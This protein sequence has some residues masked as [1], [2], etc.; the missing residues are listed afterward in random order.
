MTSIKTSLAFRMASV[1][2]AICLVLAWPCA[3]AFASSIP[4]VET[5]NYRVA[6]YYSANFNMQDDAGMRSGYGYEA[7][8]EI[9]KHMQCTFSY[10]GYDK[11]PDESIDMLRNGELDLYTAAKK[12]PEREAEFAFSSHPSITAV[13][14]MNVKVGNTKV[15]AGDYSTYDGLRIGLLSRHTYNDA[16]IRFT[17]EKGFDC[18]IVYYDTPADLSNALVNDEVDALVNSYIRTPEDERVV[19]EFGETPYYFMARQEDKALIDAIDE[20]VDAMNVETPNWRTNLYN[21]YYGSADKNTDLTDSEQALLTQLRAE[22]AVVRGIMNPDGNPYSWYEGDEAKGI[23]AELFRACAQELGL[24][25]EI[26][27]AATREEYL[28]MVRSGEID[29]WIDT[30]GGYADAGADYRMTDAYLYTTVSLLRTSYASGAVGKLAVVGSSS[31]MR[32]IIAANWP[33]AEIV[34]VA[35]TQECMRAVKSDEVDAALLMTYTAQNLRQEDAQNLLHVDIVP[36]ATLGICMG[37]NANDTRDFYGIWE[38]TLYRVAQQQSSS[39]VQSYIEESV[40][41]SIGKYVLGHP[42]ILVV[43]VALVLLVV[44]LSV[45]FAMSARAKR[46]QQAI[47]GQLAAALVEAESANKVKQNFFS[48]MSHDIRTP[49]NVVLGMTQIA[50]T[51]KNDQAKLD[52][53]LESIESEGNY[54]LVL[55]NSILDVNQIE[56]G[57]VELK[58]EAFCP[59]AEIRKSVS[60]LLPLAEKKNQKLTVDCEGEDRVV[61]GDAGRFGQIAL[62]IVSNAIKYTGQ[63][64]RIEVSLQCSPD[65]VCRFVCSDNGIGM[66]ADFVSHIADDYARAEDSRVSKTQG[67]GLGMS[68]VKGFTELM[69]GTLTVESELGRGSRFT[70]EIPFAEATPEQRASVLD[71]FAGKK[72]Y[73]R[74]LAG[75]RVLL[76]E[77]NELNAEIA[78]ELLQNIGLTVERAENG[79]QA[80]ERFESSEVGYYRA[81]FMDMQM[82]V[83]DGVEATRII[84]ASERPDSGLPIFAMTANTFASDR[85][86]C[87][88]AGMTDFISKPVDI[89]N[90]AAILHASLKL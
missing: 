46:R 81:I 66:S 58:N 80:C 70:V 62:N 89:D 49:L 74:E 40:T 37:V 11:T 12:T 31:S 61:V 26:V 73:A 4:Q 79:K 36:G 83:M 24:E 51:C 55:I 76:A 44:F 34:E 59:V 33:N 1:F 21:K 72:D 86:Q 53:A 23:T 3:P 16:F 29:V 32:E 27:P 28:D 41:P 18:T 35:D 88:D 45:L 38:K 69:G 13:T 14:T 8:Q 56:Y 9:A 42:T 63:G 50:R 57:H 25:C 30:D 43:V 90:V 6:F 60:L 67:T 84:R 65:G 87:L 71:S 52:G 10:V 48:K 2:L 5:P 82:P 39:T 68:V 20:A 78:I 19:E 7:M 64:G 47:S 15:V 85:R 54:L 17:K 75:V 22:G 77:D